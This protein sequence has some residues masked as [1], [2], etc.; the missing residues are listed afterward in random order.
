[1]PAYP[2][3]L[4]VRYVYDST[5]PNGRHVK[6]GD[7]AVI[8]DDQCVLAAGWIDSIEKTSGR[9]IRA[10]CPN[11]TSTDFKYRT[12]KQF[13]YRCATCAT[14]FET[15]AEEDLTVRVFTAN[16]SRTS[17][18]VDGTFPV[19]A[20]GPAYVSMSQQ[21]A[22]RRLDLD[23]LRPLLQ[24]HLVT[25]APWWE[26][27]VSDDTGIP[28]GHGVGASKTRLGQ[29]RFREAMFERFGAS[30]AFTGPQPPGALEA[31]HMYLYAE[32]PKHDRRGGL[33]LRADLHAL[34]DRFLIAIDPV[35]WSIQIAPELKLYPHLAE[36]DGQAV[37]LAEHLRPRLEYVQDHADTAH[38]SWK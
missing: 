2:D 28:G 3:E 21:N 7:L 15:P 25:G 8:R 31:A 12:K 26:S 32:N 38:A 19:K 11:C 16:Y 30:C 24:E 23:V 10:R 13:A 9:K 17:R 14:E 35:S 1:V 27:R 36:L 37:Q 29:Q 4:E 18:L 6:V 33:L 34:F 5:V 22:I 20:L